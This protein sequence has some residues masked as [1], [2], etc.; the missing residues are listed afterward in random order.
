MTSRFAAW[1]I[2]LLSLTT[3]ARADDSTM[4]VTLLATR[5]P[6]YLPDRLG[7]ATLVQAKVELLLFDVGYGANQR[8]YQSRINQ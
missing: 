5:C 8:L 4:T 7:I 1:L 3:P 2:L 6:E